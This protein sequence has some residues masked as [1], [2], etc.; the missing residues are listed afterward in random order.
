MTQEIQHY[1]LPQLEE[2]LRK[3]RTEESR[4]Q[5][6]RREAYEMLR[7]DCIRRMREGAQALS[8]Q[9]AR[10]HKMMEDDTRAFYAIMQ[11]YG[12]LRSD[13]QRSFTIQDEGFKVEVKRNKI[14]R[15]DERADVAA[16]RLIEFLKGWI[17]GQET[18]SEDPMYQLAMTLLERNRNGDLDYKSISKLY[19]LESR[20]G[21]PEYSA[22]MDLFRES[23]RVEGSATNYY[24]HQRDEDGVWRRL[25]TSFNRM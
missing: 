11:E 2:M 10:F 21:D 16:A 20:F 13:E 8:E 3:K 17:R 15:F 5:L 12:M 7:N 9:A 4:R 24:F 22:I 14:K 18:G 6:R 1:S 25:E 19:D 23:N